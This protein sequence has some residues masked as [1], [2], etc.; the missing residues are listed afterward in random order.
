MNTKIIKAGLIYETL[1]FVYASLICWAVFGNPLKSF[2]LT[3]II[4]LTKYPLYYLYH[5]FIYKI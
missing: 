3:L 2:M 4:T 1:V 5:R